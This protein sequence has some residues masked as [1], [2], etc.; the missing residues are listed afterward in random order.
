MIN[1]TVKLTDG[2]LLPRLGQGTWYMGDQPSKRDEE[3][4]SLR[5]GVE[6][7][8][9]VIDTAEMYGEGN[10]ESMVGEAL[11]GIR[12][13]VF[14]VSKVYPHHAGLDHIAKCCES[15]LKRLQTD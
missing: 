15:S 10:S 6:L 1:R 5:L 9:S 3:I 7:G 4:Q 2:T 11:K 8:M 12:D 14:L 13:D